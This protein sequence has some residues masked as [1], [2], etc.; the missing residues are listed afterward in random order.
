MGANSTNN[1]S[2]KQKESLLFG[3]TYYIQ[4]N[5]QKGLYCISQLKSMADDKA[6]DC[7]YY[8]I[9]LDLLLQSMG[10]LHDRFYSKDT[11]YS[12]TNAK[13]YSF[14]NTQYPLLSNKAIRNYCEHIDEREDGLIK[15]YTYFGTFNVVFQEMDGELKSEL[16]NGKHSNLL[17]L[18][19]L[20][21]S[22]IDPKQNYN[23]ITLDLNA[24]EAELRRIYVIAQQ[25][26]SLISQGIFQI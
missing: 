19:T 12:E 2:R 4:Y 21:Y 22:I 14:D 16:L 23:T 6:T 26:W 15:N 5:S 3:N 10:A 24:L 25:K 9:Y 18:E 7:F 11:L 1:L 20:Q 13:D 8:H 17:N